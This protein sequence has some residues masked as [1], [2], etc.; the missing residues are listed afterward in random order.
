MKII[1]VKKLSYNDFKQLSEDFN[2]EQLNLVNQKGVYSYENMENFERF[3]EDKLPNKK[4]LL[5]FKK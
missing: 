2:C 4:K 1:L 5:A 3:F